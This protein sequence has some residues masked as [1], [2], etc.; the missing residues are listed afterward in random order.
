MQAF[1][2]AIVLQRHGAIVIMEA[3]ETV[4]EAAGGMDGCA[5]LPA[6]GIV[7]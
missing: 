6:L 5:V 1:A 4:F 3:M 7:G 2:A